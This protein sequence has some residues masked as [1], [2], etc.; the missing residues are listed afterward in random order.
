MA[1]MAQMFA[2]EGTRNTER[3]REWFYNDGSDVTAGGAPLLG[4]V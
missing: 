2:A 3:E 4:C 1:Q